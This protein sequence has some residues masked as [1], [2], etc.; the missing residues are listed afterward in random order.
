MSASASKSAL[1]VDVGGVL[2]LL[3]RAELAPVIAAFGGVRTPDDFY[4]A[5]C[6]AHNAARPTH[7]EPRDY[8]ELLP[9]Y[10][11]VPEDRRPECSRVYRAASATRNMW[12][13]PDPH[14]KAALADFT[15]AGVKV[16]IVSQADGRIAEML[17]TARM[18]QQG[19]GPGIQVD[20]VFDSAV[21][22]LDK[23]DPRF[24]LHAT[25][26]LGVT[27]DQ[28]VHVGD[29]VPADVVGARNAGIL[30]VHYDPFDDCDAPDD[31]DHVHALAEMSRYL[32][33]APSSPTPR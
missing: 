3:N 11:G 18:C 6:A 13:D 21:V 9:A 31:H 19:R 4:R 30:A 7:G 25:T 24:F 33:S 5:H 16:A 29:T 22:G 28:A 32:T 8:Y 12:H 20:R 17:L 14:S 23:P 2:L 26:E 1:L 27:P 10:A 15:A